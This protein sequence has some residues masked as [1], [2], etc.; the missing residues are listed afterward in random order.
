M[1]KLQTRGNGQIVRKKEQKDSIASW[2]EEQKGAIARALPRHMDVDRMTRLVLT[3]FRTN[4]QLMACSRPS[5]AGC[6]MTACQLGLEPNTP[7]GFCYLIPRRIKGKPECTFLLG[8]QGMMELARRS[9][10]TSYVQAEIVRE[11]DIFDFEKGLMPKLSHRPAGSVGSQVT[12]AY[13]IAHMKDSPPIFEV[14]SRDEIEARRSRSPASKGGPWVTDYEAMCKK[15]AIRALFNWLPRSAELQRVHALEV[16]SEL[17][18]P[19]YDEKGNEACLADL[20]IPDFDEETGEVNEGPPTTLDD[21]K[22]ADD[23]YAWILANKS[24]ATANAESLALTD[25]M[26]TE[27]CE[28]L[29]LPHDERDGLMAELGL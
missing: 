10:M 3:A 20:P 5:L 17:G 11:G 2:I 27:T 14:L 21:C 1:S 23:V 8:Y 24:I 9:G 16:A 29:K 7:M 19:Q 13:A 4:P 12:H 18:Q 15:T 25:K 6:I 26:V 28:R 22:N